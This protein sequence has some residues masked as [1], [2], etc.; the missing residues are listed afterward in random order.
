I[1]RLKINK[2][3][4]TGDWDD[5]DV[6]KVGVSVYDLNDWAREREKGEKVPL[7]EWLEAKDSDRYEGVSDLE[8]YMYNP[9]MKNKKLGF[10]EDE[11][12]DAKSIKASD[13][14]YMLFEASSAKATG[15][16][17]LK[18][19]IQN[20]TQVAKIIK[21]KDHRDYIRREEVEAI[22]RDF[23]LTNQGR[24][25]SFGE[26][27]QNQ[28]EIVKK[29]TKDTPN[30]SQKTINTWERVGKGE[31][32]HIPENDYMNLEANIEKINPTISD[33]TQ[34][35]NDKIVYNV[36]EK[37]LNDYINVQSL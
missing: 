16:Q 31:T 28:S 32:L 2:S 19:R 9:N 5:R 12:I 24:R 34:I 15:G 11:S 4:E 1:D 22:I 23:S 17:E 36:N 6:V 26:M 13:L 10:L 25:T 27:S 33:P 30:V 18:E 37:V 14:Y 3:S 21:S 8:E 20:M 7:F 35:P 29:Q